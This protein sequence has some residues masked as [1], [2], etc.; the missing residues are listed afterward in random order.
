MERKKKAVE[1]ENWENWKE[2]LHGEQGLRIKMLTRIFQAE[3]YKFTKDKISEPNDKTNSTV[4]QKSKD[5][6]EKQ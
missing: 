2:E 4:L 5:H 1:D 6:V 3:D